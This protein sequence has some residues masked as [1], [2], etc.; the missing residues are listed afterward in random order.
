M[1]HKPLIIFTIFILAAIA[2]SV[3]VF[4]YRSYIDKVVLNYVSEITICE[5]ILSE[6]ECFAKD[7]CEGI[8]GPTCPG[9]PSVEFVGCQRIPE[10]VAVKIGQE[11][12]ICQNTGGEWY[13]NNLGSFCLCQ[14]NGGGRIFDKVK[15]CISR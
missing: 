2:F 15:G 11:Q 12:L 14:K 4:I 1:K 13:K 7:F 9:C 5:N 6:Q 8:Y 3:F 10:K